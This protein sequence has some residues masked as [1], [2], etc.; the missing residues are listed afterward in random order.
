MKPTNP[1]NGPKQK[2]KL[3][4]FIATGGSPKDYK[5]AA[6]NAVWKGNAEDAK[7]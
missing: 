7:K 5:G 6:E 1:K 4:K 3:H 2:M